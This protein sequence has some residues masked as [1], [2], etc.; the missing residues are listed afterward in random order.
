MSIGATSLIRMS[1]IFAFA[2]SY[3]SGLDHVMALLV[4][5]GKASYQ[6]GDG[7]R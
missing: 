6:A 4:S 2:G 7:A 1:A 3:R 5:D